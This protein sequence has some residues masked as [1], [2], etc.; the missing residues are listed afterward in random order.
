MQ[1]LGNEGSL[2]PRFHAMMKRLSERREGPTR[3]SIA[4]L[5]AAQ[6]CRFFTGNLPVQDGDDWN[7]GYYLR[8]PVRV[9]TKKKR[10]TFD[11][12]DLLAQSLL[13]LIQAYRVLQRVYDDS[14]EERQR[15]AKVFAVG[16]F[17]SVR[18]PR[19]GA[20]PWI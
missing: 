17:A 19:D 13:F 7:A 6:K 20:N 18:W 14:W 12:P 4:A 5:C 2:P 16:A 10:G 15:A 11:L 1:H 8:A 3:G 9:D